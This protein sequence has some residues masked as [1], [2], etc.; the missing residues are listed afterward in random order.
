MR[1]PAGILAMP[2]DTFS[3]KLLKFVSVFVLV[4]C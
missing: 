2:S 1:V 4:Y 3:Q